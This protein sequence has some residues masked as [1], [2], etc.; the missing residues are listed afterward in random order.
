MPRLPSAY[1]RRTQHPGRKHPGECVSTNRLP[2]YL[3][4]IQTPAQP[5]GAA[6]GAHPQPCNLFHQPACMPRVSR[7]KNH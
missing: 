5:S 6:A 7:Q 3:L 2:P 4:V 1:A